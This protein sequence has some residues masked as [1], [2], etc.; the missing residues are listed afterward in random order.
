MGA[1]GGKEHSA[2]VS[3]RQSPGCLFLRISNAAKCRV[4]KNFSQDIKDSLLQ[5]LPLILTWVPMTHYIFPSPKTAAPSADG[6]SPAW[7]QHGPPGHSAPRI[8]SWAWG[9]RLGGA[10]GGVGWQGLPLTLARSL[11]WLC[12]SRDVLGRQVNLCP[13]WSVG[14]PGSDCK[15]TL[16]HWQMSTL[17]E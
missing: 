3:R 17:P 5:S 11:Q 2:G 1:E 8:T 15:I 14:E 9:P 16:W 10:G 4:R 7:E 6:A 12:W 13:L